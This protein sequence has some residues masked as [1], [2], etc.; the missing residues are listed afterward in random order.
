MTEPSPDGAAQQPKASYYS[1]VNQ[2]LLQVVP[3]TAKR[4]YEFGCGEGRLGWAYKTWNPLVEYIGVELFADPAE[5]AKDV[6]DAVY[7]GSA[8]D[9]ELTTAA[10]ENHGEADVLVYGDVLEHLLD[11]WAALQDHL[12]LLKDDGVVCLCVPNA[13]HWMLSLN[14]MAGHFEYQDS[15]LH[16][17]THLRFFTGRSVKK[18]VEGAGLTISKVIRRRFGPTPPAVLKEM[19]KPLAA[20]AKVSEQALYDDLVTFQ[21]VIQAVR[22][23]AKTQVRIDWK[24][25]P[26]RGG[27]NV[28]RVTAPARALNSLPGVTVKIHGDAAPLTSQSDGADLFVWQRPILKLNR[29]VAQISILRRRRKLIVTDFDDDPDLWPE[30]VDN[31]HLSFVG[32]HAVQ[33]S[34][35][36]LLEKIKQ[37]NP[38]TFLIPNKISQIFAYNEIERQ[39]EPNTIFIGGF[40]RGLDFDEFADAVNEFSKQSQRNWR[41]LVV[42]DETIHSALSTGNKELHNILPYDKY[43][44]LLR[45]A[46]FALLPSGDTPLNKHKSNLKFLEAASAGTIAIASR[47]VY[48]SSITEKATGFLF[49]TPG[50]L[51]RVLR[52]IEEYP[53]LEQIR[54]LAY[55]QIRQSGLLYGSVT[56]CLDLYQGLYSRFDELDNALEQRLSVLLK[57]APQI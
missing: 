24:K 35:P 6:L 52:E 12:R 51:A 18:F 47:N 30:I 17:R 8:E 55:D 34:T 39:T 57:Q 37:W 13:Q 32:S 3:A 14:L 23:P 40:N 26:D 1:N 36:S 27:F 50:D 45:R 19:C 49:G 46:D 44:N 54:A 15:G 41:F 9:P 10:L 7:M 25:L 2:D 29:D 28:T 5:R 11:P 16:D 48:G 53:N 4:V 56:A 38:N 33:V 20:S 42:G 43:M 22:Q 31:G 21:Y